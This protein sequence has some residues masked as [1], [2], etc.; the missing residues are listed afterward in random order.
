MPK[1]LSEHSEQVM[2]QSFRV[3]WETTQAAGK[4]SMTILQ[5]R[6][7]GKSEQE[8]KSFCSQVAICLEPAGNFTKH[9]FNMYSRFPDISG[10]FACTAV[11]THRALVRAESQDGRAGAA[12]NDSCFVLELVSQSTCWAPRIYT[13]ATSS[14]SCMWNTKSS[15]SLKPFYSQHS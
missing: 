6:G 11:Y 9:Q 7:L 10:A 12:C 1:R 15:R 13:E 5:P 4:C 2:L 8:D 14:R 3:D